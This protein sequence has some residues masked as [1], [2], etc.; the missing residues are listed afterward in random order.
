MF[1]DHDRCCGMTTKTAS[2]RDPTVAIRPARARTIS[3]PSGRTSDEIGHL[4][5]EHLATA[6][7]EEDQRGLVDLNER[8]IVVEEGDGVGGSLEQKPEE[9]FPSRP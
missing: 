4:D 6:T 1:I 3:V 7:S 5:P 8:P 2:R 9:P